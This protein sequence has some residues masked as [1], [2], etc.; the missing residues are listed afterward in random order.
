MFNLHHDLSLESKPSS[1]KSTIQQ[2]QW[3]LAMQD[4]LFAIK[5]QQTW[6]LI[7]P[8]ENHKIFGYKWMF[9]LKMNSDGTIARYKARL[10]AQGYRQQEE[11][12]YFETFSPVEKMA[13]V[14]IFLT[15]ITY[16]QWKI[17][18]LDVSNAFL[19]GEL[20]EH[21]YMRQTQGFVDPNLPSHVCKLNKAI[22]ELKQSPRLWFATLSSHMQHLGFIQSKADPVLH[23]FQQNNHVVYF[24]VYVDDILIS[25][26]KPEIASNMVEN[27]KQRFKMKDLGQLSTFLGVKAI[28]NGD[29]LFLSHEHYVMDILRKF[30]KK[31]CQAISNLTS[32]K[33]VLKA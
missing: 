25:S 31:T 29:T 18:Q 5:S 27:L 8:N 21:I 1:Y 13:M 30:G 20:F 11:I 23:I 28:Q 10:V 24:L 12:D 33:V 17:T 7:A 9:K 3:Y 14:C 15:I 19:H 16:L 22:Y 2:P 32:S 6:T 26:N 4:K